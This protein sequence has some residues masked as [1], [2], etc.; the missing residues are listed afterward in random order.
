MFAVDNP[1]MWGAL[2]EDE[3][4]RKRP[5]KVK[6]GHVVHA[7]TP[8][9]Y[10][11]GPLGAATIADFR[12]AVLKEKGPYYRDTM[13]SHLRAPENLLGMGW[14]EKIDIWAVG[15][16][17]WY[18]MGN[19]ELFSRQ[20]PGYFADQYPRQHLA[21]TWSLLGPPPEDWR[22]KAEATERYGDFFD[23]DGILC[24]SLTLPLLGNQPNMY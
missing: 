6:D 16:M 9:E 20:S 19:A 14:D 5:C 3:W 18:I 22:R 13:D 8:L 24:P 21:Q 10:H 11:R 4:K 15:L 17:T 23:G 1:Y 7:T 12:R 2:Q